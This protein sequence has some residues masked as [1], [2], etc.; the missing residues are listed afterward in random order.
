M[1]ARM[2]MG[3]TTNGSSV[4]IDP[5][6]NAVPASVPR[7]SLALRRK[8]FLLG[9]LSMPAIFS[10]GTM[11]CAGGVQEFPFPALFHWHLHPEKERPCWRQQ[12]RWALVVVTPGG[13]GRLGW[14][15][16][17]WEH[18]EQRGGWMGWEEVG[19]RRSLHWLRTRR[20]IVFCQIHAA[21][22]RGRQ[23]WFSSATP[24]MTDV[25]LPL[26]LKQS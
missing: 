17:V 6:A 13:N 24:R 5:R 22:S 11:V 7:D 23:R 12:I 8:P 21:K 16:K 1:P 20:I 4:F 10:P 26:G 25:I 9:S 19:G 2:S 15:K 14:Y 3:T 18:W